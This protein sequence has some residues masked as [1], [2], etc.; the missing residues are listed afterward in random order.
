MSKGKQ[1][2]FF[3]LLDGQGDGRSPRQVHNRR[4]RTREG[5]EPACVQ[6][7][8]RGGGT[9]RENIL[10]LYRPVGVAKTSSETQRRKSVSTG[11]PAGRTPPHGDGSMYSQANVRAGK[12]LRPPIRAFAVRDRGH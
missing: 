1:T 9:R 8:W 6:T 12:V 5:A 3:T 7:L 11:S 10:P 4:R 2:V